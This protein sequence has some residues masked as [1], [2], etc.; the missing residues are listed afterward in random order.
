MD[1]NT[2]DKINCDN[3][4]VSRV[5]DKFSAITYVCECG[6]STI[7]KSNANKHVKTNKCSE[8]K[9]VKKKINF[10]INDDKILSLV[11]NSSTH[12]MSDDISTGNGYDDISTGNGYDDIR[13]CASGESCT[14]YM[15]NVSHCSELIKVEGYGTPGLI[16]YVYDKTH[17]K[18]G[19]ICTTPIIFKNAIH[20]YYKN[21][22]RDPD[23]T[24]IFTPD[25]RNVVTFV[26]G[27]LLKDNMIDNEYV[28][29][30]ID[31]IKKFTEYVTAYN[32]SLYD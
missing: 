30:C 21:L 22:F 28:I 26:R 31:S 29:H 32:I 7:N 5:V 24:T 18:R 17:S 6:Y 8:K 15:S 11:T 25:T 10:V 19:L 20:E 27:M 3:I 1:I 16:H 4:N 2:C 14:T 13:S 23:I 9:I 12:C